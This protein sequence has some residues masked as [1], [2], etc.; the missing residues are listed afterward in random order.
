M[1]TPAGARAELLFLMRNP[2]HVRNFES[3][4][5]TL[6]G[7]GRRVAVVFEEHKEGE[8]RAGL[9]LI[10]D[11]CDEHDALSYEFLPE[12]RLG[13]RGVLRK[14]LH[15]GQDYLRYF[16]P[17][18]DGADRLRARAVA[19]LSPPVERGLAAA[20]RRA[21]WLRHVLAAVAR[22][23]DAL[24]GDDRPVRGEL[25]RRRPQALIVTPLIHFGSR[26]NAWVGAARRLGIGTILCIHSWDN[27]TNRGLIHTLPDRI[28]VWN[29]AQRRQAVELHGAGSD[30]VAVTGAWPYDHWFG[31]E[32][33]RTRAELC[34]E[35]GVPE[36]R[37]IILY[38]C[39][40]SF[41][42]ERERAAVARWVEALRSAGDPRTAT[43][44]VIVRPHPLNRDE[45]MDSSQ[46]PLP[47]VTIFPPNGADPVSSASK[48]DYFDSLAHADAVVGV[49]T[50]ALIESAIVDRP[51]LAFPAPDFRST[52]HDLPHFRE[53]I[54]E[55][56]M[57]RVSASMAEHV[58]QLTE[59]LADPA[60]AV[61]GQ[62]RFVETFV[63]PNGGSPAP[64]EQ[65]TAA[66][67]ELLGD[68]VAQP[69]GPGAAATIPR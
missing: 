33:S 34:R 65:V 60:A 63:R 17:P 48:A 23:L 44:N 55:R 39:S 15:M 51:A 27:L 35:L 52:Q 16:D 38:A 29:H 22:R 4:L 68:S 30:S 49:N 57:V 37:A 41:I 64:T 47:G 5:R 66:I 46:A 40:S 28:A 54:G 59:V 53:L 58:E 62:R 8:D 25:E 10:A 11:L 61:P 14:A 18:Y 45:W 50:S 7:R 20:L 12:L 67:E 69:P 13:A 19:F 21:G 42:A 3:V 2:A 26:Q 56:G 1:S 36:D 32:A 24:L 9:A 31:W 6:A 43:A